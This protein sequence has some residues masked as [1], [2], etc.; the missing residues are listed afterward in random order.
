MTALKLL[1]PSSG[2]QLRPVG[3]RGRMRLA[4]RGWESSVDL[5]GE[6]ALEAADDLALRQA[7]G[8]AAGDVVDRRL[9]PASSNDDGAVEGGVGLSVALAIQTVAA[10]G[11]SGVGGDGAGA[12]QM[13]EGCP[14]Q[15][16]ADAVGVVPGGDQHLG[17]DGAAHPDQREQ[18]PGGRRR[19]VCRR[20]AASTTRAAWTP[21]PARTHARGAAVAGRV[22]RCWLCRTISAC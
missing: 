2:S 16:Q 15:L 22:V 19:A 5:A 20:G 9:V 3:V 21:A 8:G 12:A 17:G 11:P 1:Y 18:A 6:V 7:L 4:R 13:G 10:V 14:D